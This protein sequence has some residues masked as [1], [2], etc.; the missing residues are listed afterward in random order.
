MLKR[1]LTI[2]AAILGF[3]LLGGIGAGFGWRWR[4]T[5]YFERRMAAVT[6]AGV[7]E[8]STSIDGHT[9]TYGEGPDNGPALLLIHGQA[10]DWKNYAPV[11]PELTK[12]YHVFAIDVLGHGG[13][14]RAPETYTAAGQGQVLSRFL[15]AVV[16][17]PVIVSGHSSGGHI[18]AWLAANDASVRGVLLED[19]PFFTTTLPE[20]EQTWNYLDLATTAHEFIAGGDSDWVLYSFERQRMW[21]FFGDSADWFKDMGRDY[22]ARH[23]GEGIRLW[24]FPPMGN[25][26]LRTANTYDPHFGDAF[27][28]GTWDD[29]W[30]Q[31]AAL[32]SLEVPATLVHTKVAYD[33]DGTL[34]AAMG[35][36]DA[37][38]ARDLIPEVIFHKVETGHGFHDED[39]EAYVRFVD[40]LRARTGL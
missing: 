35:E 11:L 7:V 40:E 36:A 33:T 23:P 2:I 30:D 37:Q 4:N 19:P 38:R 3:V 29:G 5:T 17:E 20:A 21:K 31:A 6:K 34:M 15:A 27:Y 39:P 1:V 28:R 22:H 10:V 32:S 18:A 13:S 14:S 24:A 16:K 9:V 12:R 26:V 25:E 8:R